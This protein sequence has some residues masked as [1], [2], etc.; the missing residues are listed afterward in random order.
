MRLLDLFCKAGGA[1]A[2]YAAAGFEVVGVD[3]EPQ[4]NYP[5][6][7]IQ[8]NALRPP[9]DLSAFDAIHASPPCQAYSAM[10]KGRWQDREHPD[11]VEPTR[12]LLKASGKPYV[13]ENVVGS[14]MINPVMLCGTM[15]DR[16]TVEGSQLRRHRLFECS[17][18][19]WAVPFCRHNNA[20][21][22]G[23]YGGGQ[24][25]KR[26]KRLRKIEMEC[27]DHFNFGV[28]ARRQ[29]MGIDWMTGLELNQAIPPC[30]TEFIGLS[31]RAHIEADSA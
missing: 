14:P 9:V 2:G 10:R 6:T 11:L 26:R 7:F 23:V 29:V 28:S 3:I 8:G 30:Y 15:F 27:P 17:W 21:A 25:P 12:E 24:H 31:L 20:A 19:V 4:K 1:A 18:F 13:I 22:I 16:Q 5:Y